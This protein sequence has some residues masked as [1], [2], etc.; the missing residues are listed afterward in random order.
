M[1]AQTGPGPWE[2]IYENRGFL[3]EGLLF[4]L[5]LTATS[6]VLGFG[7]GL[8]AGIVETYGDGLGRRLV[9]R[10]G[11]LLRGT[12]I[13]ILLALF[14]FVTPLNISAFVAATLGIG[15]RSA[16][17]Q[18]QIFRG[19]LQS[20]SEGQMEAARSVGLSKAEAIRHVTVPQALRRSIPG[21]Q[22][23]FTIVLKD[24][25]VAYAIGLGELLTNGTQLYLTAEGNTAVLE[26]FLVISA[27]YFVLT[28]TA[29]RSLD[30]LGRVYAIP[31][32]ESR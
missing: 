21:F 23:E 29:N 22:N 19:S 10:V 12:P 32:G 16:A 25:S 8:P 13:V 31:G 17:Y 6:I 30:L 24:T 20:V 18:S 15:L 7:V 1:L 27:V 14:F 28:M 5:G 9:D 3:F 2:F 4:T 26:I 11:V